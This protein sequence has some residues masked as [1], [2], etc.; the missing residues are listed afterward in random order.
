LNR[1]QEQ[2]LTADNVRS[3]IDLV[4]E[5][6][7]S[8]Q[9]P[10]AEETAIITALAA[11]DAKL[12]R[13][14]EALERGLLSLDDAAHRIKALRHERAALLKTKADLAGKSRSKSKI[15]PIPTELMD[16]Y[17]REMQERLRANKIG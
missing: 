6:A 8:D 2:I 15:L 4:L 16:R 17:I 5:Q 7:R 1:V 12:G 3:Y 10:S 9:R 11:A 14:E 13:W